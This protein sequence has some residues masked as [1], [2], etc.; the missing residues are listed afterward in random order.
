VET[1][2]ARRA[3]EQLIFDGRVRVGR[4]FEGI[5]LAHL[6]LRIASDPGKHDS[7]KG[8]NSHKGGSQSADG[9]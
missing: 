8:G 7:I 1:E 4:P 3:S 5:L 6:N 9:P 2:L